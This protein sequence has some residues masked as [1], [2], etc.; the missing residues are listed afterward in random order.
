MT[1]LDSAVKRFQ[2]RIGPSAVFDLDDARQV[3]MI[4]AWENSDGRQSVLYN[5]IV[6]AVRA[7]IPGF[8]QRQQLQSVGLD[9]APEA[10]H[11]DTPE[12]L[13]EARQRL[14]IMRRVSMCGSVDAVAAVLD[15]ESQE[16]IAARAGVS[17]AV[18]GR[19]IQ[20]AVEAVA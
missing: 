4:A 5:S 19:R 12:A 20:A 14:A 2:R 17:R 9:A 7:V 13:H 1:P 8:R 10:V 18:V 15:G 3:G 6:D 11:H 16:S